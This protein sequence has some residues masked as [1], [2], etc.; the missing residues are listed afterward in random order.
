MSAPRISFFQ[1]V[2]DK[3]PSSDVNAAWIVTRA[4]RGGTW[5][6]Q[7]EAIRQAKRNGHAQ[8]AEELKKRLPAVTPSGRF[9]RRAKDCLIEHSG[10]MPADLDN[11]GEK[12]PLVRKQ[13]EGSPYLF[14]LFLSPSGYGLKAWVK[15]PPDASKHL[16]SFRAVEHH[17][18]ELTGVQIDQSG[19]DPAR[20]CFASFDP[21]AYH[22]PSAIELNPLPLPEKPKA[23]FADVDLSERQR[24]ALSLLRNVDWE[25]ET[26]GYVVCPGRHLHTTADGERDCRIDFDK[27]P[28]LHCFHN[29]CS[30]ILAGVNH[31][32]RSRIGKAEFVAADAVETNGKEVRSNDGSAATPEVHEEQAGQALFKKLSKLHGTPIYA[33]RRDRPTLN[34]PFFAALYAAENCVLFEADEQKFYQY[35]AEDGL[36]HFTSEHQILRW[37]ERRLLQASRSSRE[38]AVLAALRSIR[39]LAGIVRHLKG[40]VE[41]KHA[42]AGDHNFI[43]VVN[44][45][46]ELS[47]DKVKLLPFS[48]EL[49]SRNGIPIKYIASAKAP[50][51]QKQL[52]SLIS[53]DDR[54]LLLK[55]LGQ[56]LTARNLT[57]RILILQGLPET[58]KSTTAQ[59]AKH[60]IG[61]RNCTE[62]RTKHLANRFEIGRLYGRTLVIGADVSARFLNEEGAYRLKAIVG[63]DMLDAE[64][65]CSNVYF[66]LTGDFNVLLTAN[67]RLVIRLAG[68]RGAWE[69]RMAIIDYET[70]RK[71]KRI[72]DFARKLIKEEG[73]GILNLAIDGLKALRADIK[74]CGDIVF[75]DE[76]RSRAKALLDESDGLRMFLKEQVQTKSGSNLTTE[77][78]VQQFATYCAERKWTMTSTIVEK[79][80]PDLMLELFNV[81]KSNNIERFI[82]GKTT[83]RKG[84]R[85]ID[86]RPEND[87]DYE[88]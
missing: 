59:V 26:S 36:Y 61:E 40:Q 42:F 81:S 53:E 54:V 71:G 50:K 75:T 9:G 29:S 37:L 67:C 72:T 84:Y 32:L 14:A 60:L 87:P 78:I 47:G 69:R 12:L 66:T 1:I 56:F 52:L 24:I 44:G 5:R 77:E 22:N 82:D 41:E 4:I 30:G 80:L 19:K 31:E 11:L 48:P 46:L 73:P 68:D 21:D 33:L 8:L 63:G 15:V 76:Q 10:L 86:W 64:K 2:F 83:E 16:A 7:I 6:K 13:L 39:Y 25:S 27:V 28:T 34:E 70:E 35:D 55:F 51:F 45:V 58:G 38:L 43:H 3:M 88:G 20:L 23:A 65:K 17:V 18:R 62:L 57:Q 85:G 74:S 49:K 79:Q